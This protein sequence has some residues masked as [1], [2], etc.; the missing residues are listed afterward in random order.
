M[1]TMFSRQQLRRLI[2]PLIVEQILAITVGM[3]D[4][5]MISYAGEAAISGVSLVD[6]I[7]VLLINIFAAVATGGAVVVSQYLGH[8]NRKEACHAA[9]QLITVSVVISTALTLISLLFRAQILTLLFGTV[10]ADV[11]ENAMVYFLISAFSFPFLAVFNACAATY[12]SMGNSKISMQVSAGMNVFNA[13]GNAILIFGFQMGTAG[14]ALST[15]AA[16]ML[17]A[18]VM[19]VLIRNQKNDV[20]VIY[21]NLIAWERGMVHRILHIAVP[22]G[23]ENG[24]FQLGRVLVVSI[25]S[26]F[27]TAQIAAN[28]VAN[29][30][31]SM[32]CIAGQAM[33]LAM[34]TVVGQCMGAGEKDQAVWYTKKL[35][36]FTY[37]I[38]AAANSVILLALPLILNIYSLSPEAWR[39][40]FILVCIHDG[41]A[42]V[43]WPTSFTLPNA[44]RASGDVK[45]T[46]V[47][48][49]ASMF[50]FR[51][52]FSV[53]LGIYFG[54][55]AI[56]VWIAMVLDWICRVSF[57]SFRF[58]SRKWLDFKVI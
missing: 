52:G 56:G 49:V 30:L 38:T 27:G 13:I 53:V 25:I 43:L 42:I 33:N 57:Y 18:L 26:R 16:R 7:N 20:Y 39:F 31:D 32:G 37:Q 45:F 21:R 34:I 17:G 46:M 3:V 41:C 6:M 47:I 55:G 40:A 14:A 9:E 10:E 4:T 15:L 35:W 28:A 51:I 1:G 19:I 24:L 11:M 8:G 58:R 50:I 48:S 5:M 2:F 23:V 22:N 36:K 29:N 54:L 44:L 12:R